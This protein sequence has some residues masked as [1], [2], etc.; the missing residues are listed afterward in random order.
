MFLGTMCTICQEEILPK[1]REEIQSNL[2]QFESTCQCQETRAM[3]QVLKSTVRDL[4]CELCNQDGTSQCDS[5]GQCIC[6]GGYTGTRCNECQ[7][8]FDKDDAGL[9]KSTK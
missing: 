5:N 2:P 7:T 9:C 4:S 8:G 6:L 1:I 3:L